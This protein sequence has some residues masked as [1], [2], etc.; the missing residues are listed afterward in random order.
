[1][2]GVTTKPKKEIV[3]D[4]N[5]LSVNANNFS[6][7]DNPFKS[8]QVDLSMLGV[9]SPSV[10][11]VPSPNSGAATRFANATGSG[12]NKVVLQPGHS[13]MDW[14][15]LTNAGQDL[16]CGRL[17][18]AKVSGLELQQHATVNDAWTAINGI[19]YNITPYFDFHPGGVDELLRAAGKDSTDLF[20]QIHA[21]VNYE[22]ML[23]KCRVGR[24]IR[25][26]NVIKAEL[27]PPEDSI[28]IDKK[29][30]TQATTKVS[31]SNSSIYT[32]PHPIYRWSDEN[33][34]V[35]LIIDAKIKPSQCSPFMCHLNND[36]ELSVTIKLPQNFAYLVH[37]QLFNKI[38]EIKGNSLIQL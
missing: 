35:R 32:L 3:V 27:N 34:A 37:L 19:V 12:R 28:R 9:P 13:I 2:F 25:D 17:G 4:P 14:I 38:K 16:T 31:T 23:Q 20:N 30:V 1:M 11:N 6:G 33:H 29:T 36:Q 18:V 5:C 7:R 22:S 26:E 21:W 24:L 10:S 15:R 8:D